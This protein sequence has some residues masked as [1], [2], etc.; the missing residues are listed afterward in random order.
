MISRFLRKTDFKKKKL[1]KA[2]WDRK[3]KNIPQMKGVS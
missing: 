1:S 2:N 3:K